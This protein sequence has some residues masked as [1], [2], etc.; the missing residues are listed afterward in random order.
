MLKFYVNANINAAIQVEELDATM[1][2]ALGVDWNEITDQEYEQFIASKA[3]IGT[4]DVTF[5]ER[6][7]TIDVDFGGDVTF[8]GNEVVF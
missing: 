6:K 5:F 7:P 4:M 8:G 3:V 2:L 1:N